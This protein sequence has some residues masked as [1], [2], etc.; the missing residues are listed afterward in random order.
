MKS[1]LCYWGLTHSRPEKSL[2]ATEELT[3]ILEPQERAKFRTF[4]ISI[5][6]VLWISPGSW[7][8]PQFSMLKAQRTVLHRNRDRAMWN[9]ARTLLSLGKK[10]TKP[11]REHQPNC[12]FSLK[13]TGFATKWA[14]SGSS[15]D[16]CAD[17]RNTVPEATCQYRVSLHDL[18]DTFCQFRVKIQE[19]FSWARALLGQHI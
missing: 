11:N 8:C 3:Y 4:N 15:L 2:Y 17:Y 1:I 7:P 12:S 18:H 6:H 14:F 10:K 5:V 16:T 9:C 19:T 13:I